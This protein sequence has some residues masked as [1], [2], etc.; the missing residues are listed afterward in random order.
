VS[1]QSES[2]QSEKFLKV[3]AISA[4]GRISIQNATLK[5][6]CGVPKSDGFDLTPCSNFRRNTLFRSLSTFPRNL[7]QKIQNSMTKGNQTRLIFDQNEALCSAK[8]QN[9][10]ITQHE[11]INVAEK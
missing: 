10:K 2:P 1:L 5:T 11:L 4:D 8:S 6:N 9:P 3:M 7:V